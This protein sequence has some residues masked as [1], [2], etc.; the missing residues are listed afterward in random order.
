MP[1]RVL[2]GGL[3]SESEPLEVSAAAGDSKILQSILVLVKVERLSQDL[4]EGW[5]HREEPIQ[6]NFNF[7]HLDRVSFRPTHRLMTP[8]PFIP[9]IIDAQLRNLEITHESHPSPL[10][11]FPLV[12]TPGFRGNGI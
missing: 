1:L 7:C 8:D 3:T 10:S 11:R 9:S 5:A 12:N 6:F 4:T 2:V